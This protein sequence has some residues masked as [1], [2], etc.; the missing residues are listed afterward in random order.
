MYLLAIVAALAGLLFGYDTGI[1]SGAMLFLK[2]TFLMTTTELGVVVS[3]V[4][5]GALVAAAFCGRLN[6]VLGRKRIL[7]I[8]A[9]LYF[10]GSITSALSPN[11]E[12]LIASRLILGFAVGLGSYS[13]PVYIAEIAK[14]EN[15]GALVTLNQLA[16]TVGIMLSYLVDYIF[17]S[18]GQWRYMLGCGFIPAL[19]LLICIFSLPESPRWLVTKGKIARAKEILGAIHGDDSK[20]EFNQIKSVVS[21]EPLT[22]RQLINLGFMRVL[23]LGIAVSIFTQAVGINAIIYYAPTIFQTA[24]LTKATSLILATAGIGMVNV[25]FTLVAVRYLD[26][27]G[28]RKML[29]FGL[30]GILFSLA[31]ATTAFAHTAVSIELAWAIM[32]S[33]VIFIA[34]QAIG[35]GPACWLIPSEI[36]PT[37]A[38]GL[39]MGLAVAFN[40]ATNVIVAFFF[41]IT[42]THLGPSITFGIF[43]AIACVAFIVF[44]LFVPETKGVSLEQIEKNIE[45]G[46]P[47]RQLGDA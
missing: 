39:G 25:L 3:A 1:I 30:G 12:V 33:F 23:L 24:G 43:L 22:Y 45:A 20:Q 4:P 16:I 37:E 28:R 18:Q 40:W 11:V 31:V 35:T 5:F 13:A 2:K 38:R 46:K 44:F 10:I 26:R 19:I 27:L 32:A 7:F 21:Q 34:S 29:L 14:Q 9:L 41:P 36:F 6:D 8:T 15:R 17:A 47:L 42:L